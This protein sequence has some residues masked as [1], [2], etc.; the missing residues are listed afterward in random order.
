[1]EF[2]VK[3]LDGIQE[4]SVQQVEQE[5]LD[6]HEEQFE[7]TQEPEKIEVEPT[8]VELKEEDVLSYIGNRYGK[9]INSFDE[10]VQERQASEEL[11]ED[12]AAYFK[13]KKETGRGINDFVKLQ[14]DFDSMD[15]DSLL[16][17]YILATEEGVDSDDVASIMEDY[18]Y[19]EDYD[20]DSTIKKKKLAK[21]KIIAKAKSYFNEQKETYKQPL[22]SRQ[23][24]VSNDAKEQLQAYQQ[25]IKEAQG[26]EEETKRKTEWFQ[27]K[28]DD[29]FNDEFKGFEFQ[30]GESKVVYNPGS[31][32][33]LKKLQSNPS[34]FVS[35]FLD[36]NGMIS[37]AAGY[38]K[39]LSIA[40]NPEKFAKFFYEQGKSEATDDVMRKAKNINMDIRR[41]PEAVSK[42]GMQI[43]AVNPDSG[44][45]LTIRSKK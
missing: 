26:Y 27:K 40:M 14:R 37:D 24:A 32:A 39:A 25:Y 3:S 13:Y 5:L 1:M 38:H 19:D 12:V 43:K 31:A 9:Q 41:A 36:E 7:G 44:R 28:T 8:K 35:K 20:D 23:D 33:E 45:G 22:E 17:E 42:G 6:K 30:L 11:P 29:V 4:K 21:K 2:Q 18:S 34:N 15:T 16:A 10:L